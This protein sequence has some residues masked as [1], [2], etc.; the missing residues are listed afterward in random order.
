MNEQTSSRRKWAYAAGIALCVLIGWLA[1]VRGVPVPLLSLVNLGFHELG[2]LVT[3]PL[4]DLMTAMMGSIAQVMVPVGLAAYFA[5]R[6]RDFLG[7]GLCLTWAGG[8]AQEVSVYIADAPYQRLPLIGGHHDWAFILG[9][10][11]SLDAADAIAAA[12]IGMAWVLT[13]A[14]IAVCVLGAVRQRPASLS[15]GPL[16]APSARNISWD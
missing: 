10:L 4:P 16:P 5:W 13:L 15:R 11:D 3:Y 2:H 8:S 1:L 9:S 6:S 14:G 12:V 7:T